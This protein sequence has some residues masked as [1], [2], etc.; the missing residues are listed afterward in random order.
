M[1]IRSRGPGAIATSSLCA[2]LLCGAAPAASQPI[3]SPTVDAP[4]AAVSGRRTAVLAGGCFW[5]VQ[6][7]FQHVR[8]V[9]QA[10]SGY[11][12]GS[13]WNAHYEVVSFGVT[14]HAE[15]VEISYDPSRISYG[16]LLRVFFSVAHDPTQRNRQGPDEGRQYRSA[17]FAADADQGRIALAYIAQLDEAGAFPRPIA[18]EV[19]PLRAF[20][21]AESYHQDYAARHPENPYIRI[22]DAPKVEK[23]AAQFPELYVEGGM[24]RTKP[25]SRPSESRGPR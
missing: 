17:I 14:G 10:V 6:A 11:S 22:N 9:I 15:S 7:V 25:G 20:Y 2:A 24:G 21:T 4:L 19:V 13:A 18:T 16:Q 3:P 23:L 5:G 12:G 1:R 8:G